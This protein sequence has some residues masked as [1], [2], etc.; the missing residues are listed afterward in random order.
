MR[1]LRLS[2]FLTMVLGLAAVFG[3]SPAT[4]QESIVAS[5][6]QSRVSITASFDGSEILIFGA[7]KRDQ[8]APE[9]DLDV[10]VTVAGPSLPTTVRRKE[11]VAG[12]WIN[13]DA[14]E[15]D[16]AP[17]FYAV[18]TTRPLATILS[19]VSDLRHRISVER[20]IRSVGA[21]AGITDSATFTEALIRIREK[22]DLYALL[23]ENTTLL[24]NTLFRTEVALPS[25]LVEGNYT[26]RIYLLREGKVVGQSDTTIFVSKVGIERWIYNLA[27]EQPLLYGLLSLFIAIVAGWGASA[28]FRYARF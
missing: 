15:V 2:L 21:P 10:I 8:P 4:A 23:E 26:T 1:H 6:S 7:I 28:I 19:D 25:N 18:S 14:V 16:A 24:E 27:H 22:Q 12:I 5:L 17:S 11:R 20:A 3:V 13:T 9:G